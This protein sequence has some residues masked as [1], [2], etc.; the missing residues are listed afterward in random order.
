MLSIILVLNQCYLAS[1]DTSSN[2][3]L[4]FMSMTMLLYMVKVMK[5]HIRNSGSYDSKV[6]TMIADLTAGA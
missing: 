4:R 5:I 1:H 3:I 2:H 6:I